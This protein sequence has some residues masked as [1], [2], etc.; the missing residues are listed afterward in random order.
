MNFNANEHSYI[1][2]PSKTIIL[3]NLSSNLENSMINIKQKKDNLSPINITKRKKTDNNFL[4]IYPRSNDKFKN[5][6]LS[7]SPDKEIQNKKK[8]F[9]NTFL[10][11]NNPLKIYNKN[12]LNISRYAK[13]PFVGHGNKLSLGDTHYFLQRRNSHQIDFH[14]RRESKKNLRQIQRELQ[15]KLVDMSIRMENNSEDEGDYIDQELNIQRK[16]KKIFTD[17]LRSNLRHTLSNEKLKKE[18][19]SE[20][21]D[22]LNK[23]NISQINDQKKNNIK[24]KGRME[25]KR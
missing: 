17:Y 24:M 5:S 3:S 23:E 21:D 1:A 18:S 22:E 8:Q 14:M 2:Q 6:L 11:Q 25:N 4:S 15:Y 20:I 13:K 10:S 7:L 16:D 19:S 9:K 12:L